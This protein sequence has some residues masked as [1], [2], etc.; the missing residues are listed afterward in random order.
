M[1]RLKQ[2]L[3]PVLNRQELQNPVVFIVD[4]VNGFVKKGA[5][6]DPAILACAA[7]MRNLVEN[8]EAAVW[9]VND[10]HDDDCAEFAFFPPHCI[11]DSEEARVIEELASVPGQTLE[12]NAISAAASLQYPAMLE[13]LPEKADLIV[14]GC[15]TD[16]CIAQ[17]ALPLRSWLN[18]NGRKDCRV[19]VPADCVETFDSPDHDA[20]FWNEAALANLAANGVLVVQGIQAAPSEE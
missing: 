15:C 19:I 11:R 17:L 7:P 6:A 5:L 3:Y 4:M 18:Q 9:F 1:A 10:C 16:L 14:T 8:L 2:N 20:F 12:K 13:T